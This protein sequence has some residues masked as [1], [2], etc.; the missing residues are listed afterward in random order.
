MVMRLCRLSRLHPGECFDI[1]I[2]AVKLT[3]K[4]MTPLMVL[5]DGYIAN[6]SAPWRL[7]DFS[8]PAYAPFPVEKAKDPT[9]FL[10]YAHD[11]IPWPVLGPCRAQ[12]S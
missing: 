7:P 4:H 1:G 2:E 10:P 12:L 9:N 3:T 11:P 5:S 6:A 8:D